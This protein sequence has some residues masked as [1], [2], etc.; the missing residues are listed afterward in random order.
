[1]SL[2]LQVHNTTVNYLE[3]YVEIPMVFYTLLMSL[4]LYTISGICQKANRD[5]IKICSERIYN[6]NVLISSLFDKWKIT[7]D[8]LKKFS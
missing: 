6:S 7:T 2:F 3:K 4:D 8:L 1:M 5:K